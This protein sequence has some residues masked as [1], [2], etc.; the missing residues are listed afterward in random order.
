MNKGMGWLPDYPSFR[1]YTPQSY[2]VANHV[3]KG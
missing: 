2:K 1:D 3:Q